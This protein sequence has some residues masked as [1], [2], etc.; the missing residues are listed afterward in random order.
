MAGRQP[1]RRRKD[2]NMAVI[3]PVVRHIL[4][5]DDVLRNPENPSKIDI[6]GLVSSIQA[7]GDFPILVPLLC[8]FVQFTNGRGIG[9]VQVAI[10][11][12][13]SEGLVSGS[14]SH[15]VKFPFNPLTVHGITF[16]LLDCI[17]TQSGLYHIE[18]CVDEKPIAVEPLLVR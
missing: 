12:A 13:D 4:V 14:K 18:F 2:M 15:S 10:R 6:Q 16:R 1:D 17:F 7:L 11:L 9:R 8:V 3:P 5:C